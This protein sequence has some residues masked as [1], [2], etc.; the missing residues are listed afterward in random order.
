[1]PFSPRVRAEGT[2][3]FTLVPAE[4]AGAAPA[5]FTL[6]TVPGLLDRPGPRRWER[7]ARERQRLPA[8]L[9]RD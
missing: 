1:A 2:V 5:D 6:A 9:L 8:A 3:S 4:L 7:L